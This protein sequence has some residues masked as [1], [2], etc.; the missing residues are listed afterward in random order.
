MT[1]RSSRV[2]GLLLTVFFLA[3]L[4]GYAVVR[5]AVNQ[6][7]ERQTLVIAEV[8]ASQA[9]TTRSVYA[10][11]IADK[12]TKDGFGPHVDSAH[13]L[14]HIPIPA[15]FLKLV[16]RASSLNSDRLYDYRPVSKWNLEATQG[17]S[18][19]FLRWAWPQLESQ[20]PASPESPVKWTPISRFEVQDGQRVLRFLSADPAA[21]MSCVNCH[22]AYEKTPKI[23]ALRL[24]SGL[25]GEKQWKQHQLLGA[26]SVTIPLSKSELL[27]GQPTNKAA[28][29]FA[30]ILIASLM[31]L[32]WFNWRMSRQTRE[33]LDAETQLAKS[34][35]QAQ[36][37]QALLLANQG[38]EHAFSE[39]TTYIQAIDQHAIVSVTDASGQILRVNEKLIKISGFS[40]EELIG[41]DHRLLNSGTHD[42]EFF[43]DLW[44]TISNGE[45]WRGLICNRAKS[46]ELYW[47]DSAI[48]P[49]EGS[50][51][52]SMKYVSIRIDV[53]ERIKTEHEMRYMATHDGLTKLANRALLRD[54]IHQALETNRRINRK[55]AVLFIDLD[56]FKAVNDSLGHDIGDLLLKE[57]ATRLTNCVRS[58]DTVARQ[59]G[60]EF[61]VLVPHLVEA[62]DGGILAKKFQT[63]LAQPFQIGERELYIGSSIAV[64]PEGGEDVDSLLKN[65]DIAMYQVKATGRNHYLFFTP[66]MNQFAVG[67]YSLG[68]DLRHAQE[69]D[70]LFLNYQPIVGLASG[71]IESME[72]LLRWQHPTRG[73]IPPDQFIPLAESLGL[74]ISIG[75]WVI[76][77]SCQ[78]VRTWQLLGYHVP[79]LAINLSALQIHHQDAMSNIEQVLAEIGV[80]PSDL[81]FEITEGSLMKN[82]GEVVSRLRQLSALGLHISLDDFGT[83]YSSLSYLKR[84]PIDTLKIDRSFVSDIGDDPND[85]AIVATIIAMGHSL[86]MTLI[87]EG[88]ETP[89]QLAFLR[90]QGCQQYQGYLYSKPLSTSDMQSKLQRRE[91]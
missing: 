70:E 13:Y 57:V 15:Q 54:R 3:C 32:L 85:T 24:A 7:V 88:V 22:N 55:A 64:S 74:I 42:R 48:V 44:Y 91:P 41:Q 19:D 31:T 80:A 23:T 72:V 47:V 18:D 82:T 26:L 63:A 52:N 61:I 45:I 2:Y 78:Q 56:Q 77:T 38:V 39:L 69:R 11:E 87:A 90:A 29:F 65:S 86:G 49:L 28:A 37:T 75:E 36:S 9:M 58:E 60:D 83:G 5:D 59:G 71:E 30:A 68:T 34:E 81:E 6:T 40:R 4:L 67:Q 53:T 76:R 16:G 33:L 62:A 46:G 17:L 51:Q 1:M 89:E 25:T 73:L 14:G 20:S 21:Q 8:V 66:D 12:L 50:T 84:L 35:L 27:A 43:A 79:R 10:S